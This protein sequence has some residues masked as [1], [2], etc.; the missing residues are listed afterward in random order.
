MAAKRYQSEECWFEDL[1][2]RDLRF[3]TALMWELAGARSRYHLEGGM[4]MA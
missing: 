3:S 4:E 2:L 1:Q